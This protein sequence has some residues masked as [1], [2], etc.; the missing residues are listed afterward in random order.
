M[1]IIKLA[2]PVAG[3]RG[4]VGGLTYSQNGAGLYVRQW[5]R[6]AN[7]RSNKQTEQ[8]ANLASMGP[9]WSALSTA[10]RAAWDTWAALP[11]Q[12]QTNALGEVYYLS[13]WQW[14][15]RI[16]TR[17]LRTTHA[18]RDA[19][20]TQSA[21]AA[22]TI[23]SLQLPGVPS[24]YAYITYP[25]GEFDPDWTAIVFLSVGPRASIA[26]APT[27]FLLQVVASSPG[28]TQLG[29]LE[30]FLGSFGAFQSDQKGFADV[31]A[32]T[33]DGMRSAPTRVTFV[34]SDSP[35]YTPTAVD[36]DG[37]TN[38][39]TRGADLTGNA[40]SDKMTL[41]VWFRVDGGSGTNRTFAHGTGTRYHFFVDTANL[42]RIV[43]RD[44]VGT[45]I[46]DAVGSTTLAVGAAWHHAFITW[47]GASNTIRMWLD[48]VEESVTVNTGTGGVDAD[49]TVANH[50]IGG[51][52]LG[53]LLW[54]GCLS[55]YYWHNEVAID[56]ANASTQR[57][58]V[59]TDGTPAYL[60]A[61]GSF[62][63]G[64]PPIVYVAGGDA[65]T[66]AGTGGNY[67]NNAALSA[68]SSSP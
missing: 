55:E 61:D 25:S 37:A 44:S 14:F 17:L 35:G 56:Y 26:A 18:Q 5:S 1:A 63:T 45:V 32:Q 68:C 6:G 2:A 58:F 28:D 19:P 42:L 53:T 4:T 16:N 9:A 12:E 60:G 65:A 47:D 62:P 66:N 33:T 39:A 48:E 21:P 46:V 50:A 43:M 67:T 57:L 40:D 38:Y 59:N 15:Q 22:P 54:D 11:A 51:T 36:Y 29:F 41:S 8:R 30:G 49:W 10:Q 24:Q 64:S 31:Y 13:G 23:S 7:P 27:T 20:P 52:I 3:I 34:T